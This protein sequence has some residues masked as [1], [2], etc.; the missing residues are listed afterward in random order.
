M[1]PRKGSSSSS[2]GPTSWRGPAG[3]SSSRPRRCSRAGS[4]ACW[5][6]TPRPSA[7]SP[8]SSRPRSGWWSS[9]ARPPSGWPGAIPQ[10]AET[11][12]RR[13]GPE[14]LTA[15]R[16][17]GDDVAEVM[18]KEGP[19]SLNVLRK[20]GKGGWSF[21]TQQVLPHKK[22]LA[23]AGRPGRVPGRPRQ[24]RRLRR[25]GHRVRRPRVRQ[26]R[27]HPGLGRRRRRG[28]GPGILDRRGPRRPRPRSRPSSATLGMAPG[29]PG[30][31]GRAAGGR[32]VAGEAACSGRSA[33]SCV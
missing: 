12:V 8:P 32:G 30:R 21:F 14:G 9:W 18:V 23:A 1:T 17:F 16:V 13:L 6:A 10:E 28:P 5:A 27:H 33:G 3:G 24:V 2:A 7:A 11:M 20:T 26:G 15:V 25:P 29:R 31:G 4:P 19:E 22:K